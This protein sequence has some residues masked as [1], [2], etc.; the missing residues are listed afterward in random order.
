MKDDT[1]IL[2]HFVQGKLWREKY[3]NRDKLEFPSYVYFDEFECGNHLASHA[4][5]EKLGGVYVSLACS[6]PYLVAKSENIF[7]STI[8]HA[9]HLKK[10]GNPII[11]QKVIQDLNILSKTGII[12]NINGNNQTVYFEC[13]LVLGDNIGVNTICG[14]NKCFL[15]KY[16]CR[17]CNAPKTLCEI[18]AVHDNSMLR[19]KNNY[20]LD[21]LRKNPTETGIQEE[22]AF[23][24]IV[25][26]H[27]TENI[28]VD[29]MHDVQ[30]GISAYTI[31]KV[32]SVLVKS[33]IISLEVLNNRIDS[34]SYNETEKSN[35]PRPLFFTNSKKGE[36]KIKVKQSASELLCLTRYLALMIGDLIS[37]KHEYWK[38]M[39]L[40]ELI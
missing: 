3:Y 38:F 39:Y 30:E 12:V 37:D 11:F 8:V 32:L 34:F 25:K 29:L 23:H 36:P 1:E 28:Y 24:D 5:E 13:A 10:F 14:F 27:I 35:K 4:G 16:Y 26:F 21:V 22:C 7:L 2:S 20:D 40:S 17:I 31:G 33:K 6:P 19:T 15:S 9:K 18:L